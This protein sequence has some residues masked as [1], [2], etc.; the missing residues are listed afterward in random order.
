M[1]GVDVWAM[2][3]PDGSTAPEDLTYY[4]TYSIHDS[5]YNFYNLNPGTYRVY[6]Q[7]WLS[8]VLYTATETVLIDDPWIGQQRTDVDLTLQ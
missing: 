8:G 5:T 6:A 3:L 1:Q 2:Q 4:A 7:V